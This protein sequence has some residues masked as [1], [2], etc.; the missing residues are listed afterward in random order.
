M[1]DYGSIEQ[2][3]LKLWPKQELIVSLKSL[4][5]KLFIDARKWA[6]LGD[7]MRPGKGL[8][9]DLEC[10]PKVIEAVNAMLKANT[11]A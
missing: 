3:T 1:I 9:L 10:W 7:T 8:M 11:N 6:M 5:G 4:E 2:T